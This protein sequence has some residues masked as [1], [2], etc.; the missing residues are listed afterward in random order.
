MRSLSA[1]FFFRGLD[2]F[3]GCSCYCIYAFGDGGRCKR[4]TDRWMR[5]P[6]HAKKFIRVQGAPSRRVAN[7]S[8]VVH[9]L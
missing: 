4:Q 3:L 8:A 5:R 9:S 2:S 7:F 6:S 1:L